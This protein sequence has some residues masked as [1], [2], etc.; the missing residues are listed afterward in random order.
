MNP[1]AAGDNLMR[2]FWRATIQRSL[3]MSV[4]G[5]RVGLTEPRRLPVYPGE[6]TFQG[7]AGM[8]Q[9]CQFQTHASQQNCYSI[10]SLASARSA[11]GI[12]RLSA[13]AV[14]RLMTSSN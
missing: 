2:L 1:L 10:T 7:S 13:L 14:L 4:S 5:L 9:G 12:A 3:P 6:R 11:G 8:S